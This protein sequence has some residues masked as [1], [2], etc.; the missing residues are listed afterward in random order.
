LHDETCG[1]NKTKISCFFRPKKKQ[2]HQAARREARL[3]SSV[4]DSK[5]KQLP[6]TVTAVDH[7][8]VR[9][10]HCHDDAKVR[11][12]TSDDN[13]RKKLVETATLSDSF[14]P[15][16]QRRKKADH[17]VNEIHSSYAPLQPPSTASRWLALAD[18][19]H[20]VFKLGAI[21]VYAIAWHSLQTNKRSCPGNAPNH[22][23]L[24]LVILLFKMAARDAVHT[25]H[26]NGKPSLFCSPTVRY[27]QR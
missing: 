22:N 24:S 12:S 13:M 2:R 15:T 23:L 5:K 9:G 20:W 3:S 18:S 19:Y 7:Q 6:A 4:V 8:P 21:E 11:S 14:P 1:H 26:T 25:P 17:S 10:K 27:G 16:E